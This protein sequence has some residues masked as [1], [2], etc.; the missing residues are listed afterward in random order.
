MLSSVYFGIFSFYHAFSA[1]HLLELRHIG[2]IREFPQHPCTIS[3]LHFFIVPKIEDKIVSNLINVCKEDTEK[4][5]SF[6]NFS[7]LITNW[8]LQSCGHKTQIRL[9]QHG[10][11][12]TCCSANSTSPSDGGEYASMYSF[13]FGF[14]LQLVLVN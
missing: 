11:S 5:L 7:F 4:K 8:N 3:L 1:L 2:F 10:Q 9:T 13:R 12:S 14:S 6:L